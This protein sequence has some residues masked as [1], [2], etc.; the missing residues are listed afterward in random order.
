MFKAYTVSLLALVLSALWLGIM[1]GP[2]PVLALGKAAVVELT[3]TRPTVVAQSAAPDLIPV[4]GG[5]ATAT[6]TDV[7]VLMTADLA[8]M[9]E[10]LGYVSQRNEQQ[11]VEITA[12][13]SAVGTLDSH[14]I[15]LDVALSDMIFLVIMLLLGTI[16]ANMGI[17]VALIFI[18]QRQN[19]I[20]R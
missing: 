15:A 7:A 10:T 2:E 4:T 14:V 19:T 12:L 16:V 18:M 6:E 11:D 8:L 1:F 9:H 13:Q 17:T 5:A 3:T 20:D